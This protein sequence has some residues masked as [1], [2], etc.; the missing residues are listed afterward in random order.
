MKTSAV[1]EKKVY[2]ELMRIIAIALVIFN[3]LNGY[4]LYQFSGGG[5]AMDLHDF[6]YD[7]KN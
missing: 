6:V 7:Y 3:H 5:Q 4:T 1:K 2:I